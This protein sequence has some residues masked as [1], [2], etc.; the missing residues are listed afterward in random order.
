MVIY[1]AENVQRVTG[2][3]LPSPAGCQTDVDCEWVITNC[4]PEM[5]G[6]HWECVNVRAWQPPICRPDVVC[7]QVISPR[8]DI[9]CECEAGKCVAG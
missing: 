8:P 6:A 7:A 5:A 2:L 3:V 4:C 9:P 1:L